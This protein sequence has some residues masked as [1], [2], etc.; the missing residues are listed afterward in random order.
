MD[1]DAMMVIEAVGFTESHL[2]Y[3][4]ALEKFINQVCEETFGEFYDAI[5]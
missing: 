4:E 5:S 2:Q 1:N 3:D